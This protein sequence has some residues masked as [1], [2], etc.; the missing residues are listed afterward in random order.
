[1][2]PTLKQA[3]EIRNAEFP[4]SDISTSIAKLSGES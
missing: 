2:F 4:I 1:M 3:Q